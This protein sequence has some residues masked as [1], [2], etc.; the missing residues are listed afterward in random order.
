MYYGPPSG[1]PRARTRLH[2]L[3]TFDFVVYVCDLLHFVVTNSF[4]FLKKKKVKDTTQVVG[5]IGSK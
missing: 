4:V 1:G 2:D 3:Q 5:S